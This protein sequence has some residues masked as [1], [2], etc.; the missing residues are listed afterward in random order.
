[1]H[2][3]LQNSAI[4]G[5]ELAGHQATFR[6]LLLQPLLLQTYQRPLWNLRKRLW[7]LV[8]DAQRPKRR[9][10]SCNIVGRFCTNFCSIFSRIFPQKLKSVLSPLTALKRLASTEPKIISHIAS[11]SYDASP[12]RA[13]DLRNSIISFSNWSPPP[14]SAKSSEEEPS[15]LGQF[16]C[17]EW[18]CTNEES[19]RN[20]QSCHAQNRSQTSSLN[21][22]GYPG[23]SQKNCR[24]SAP[25]TPAEGSS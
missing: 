23:A 11:S 19:K 16:Q 25:P 14:C 13:W 4:F 3:L 21:T 9:T 6:R 18:R 20:G 1:M 17:S 12:G 10:I 22:R 24:R 7:D 15:A 5:T 2:F 8:R